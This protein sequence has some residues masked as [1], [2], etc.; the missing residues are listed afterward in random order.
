MNS[1]SNP[2][3]T[4]NALEQYRLNLHDYADRFVMPIIKHAIGIH[5][6]EK[7]EVK[8]YWS[9]SSTPTMIFDN[10]LPDDFDF[11]LRGSNAASLMF[12]GF[13][14]SLNFGGDVRFH[15]HT[16]YTAFQMLGFKYTNDCEV[17][18]VTLFL[19]GDIGCNSCTFD[20]EYD[21]V[22]YEDSVYEGSSWAVPMFHVRF[23]DGK[24]VIGPCCVVEA[25]GKDDPR[26]EGH[27][28]KR[29]VC[30]EMFEW[31]TSKP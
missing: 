7:P 20:P 30:Y 4:K 26:R 10:L 18:D 13:K 31:Y 21:R 24:H 27:T 8:T 17:A 12:K 19:M 16:D 5:Y 6:K 22:E 15:F 23:K 1:M 28:D 25:Y 14:N 2:A 3:S 29:S 9:P 11:D